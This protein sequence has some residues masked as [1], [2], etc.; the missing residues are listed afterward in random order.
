MSEELDKSLQRMITLINTILVITIIGIV[1]KV[2][3]GLGTII[4]A[5]AITNQVQQ[6]V[7]NTT[8]N[9]KY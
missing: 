5:R 2:G 9:C 7:I 3:I 6:Q 4:S 8:T 1:A